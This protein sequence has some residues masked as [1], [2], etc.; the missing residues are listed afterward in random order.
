MSAPG[1]GVSK[2][3]SGGWEGLAGI[4][5]RCEGRAGEEF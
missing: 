3:A 1:F 5:N 4:N 2:G